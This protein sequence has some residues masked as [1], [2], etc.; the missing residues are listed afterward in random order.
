[1]NLII[2]LF[3]SY[4]IAICSDL[5]VTFA[6]LE[7]F[8]NSLKEKHKTQVQ[9]ALNSYEDWLNMFYDR[10]A[11]KFQNQDI[12]GY[13]WIGE[14]IA[15]AKEVIDILREEINGSGFPDLAY[16][17]YVN[18]NPA[19]GF[20]IIFDTKSRLEEVQKA[21]KL[22]S[23]GKILDY[24]RSSK[25]YNKNIC[26][27]FTPRKFNNDNEAG[28]C[29]IYTVDDTLNIQDLEIKKKYNPEIDFTKVVKGQKI[30]SSIG[31]Y[32]NDDCFI[33]KQLKLKYGYIR[34]DKTDNNKNNALAALKQ[35]LH[36]ATTI[37][38][39]ESFMY[40]NNG[41]IG[42][43]WIGSS[44][45]NVKFSN[46][47]NLFITEVTTY[48]IPVSGFLEY[49][50]GNPHET[51]GIVIYTDK[52]RIND[53][54]RAGKLWSMG[55]PF[56]K[57]DSNKYYDNQNLC[58]LNKMKTIRNDEGNMDN[59]FNV[60][61][62]NDNLGF[63]TKLDIDSLRGYNP[64]TDFNNLYSGQVICESIG[65]LNSNKKEKSQ[66]IFYGWVDG[67]KIDENKHNAI[68]LLNA[69][70]S[71]II[72]SLEEGFLYKDDNIVGY[73]WIGSSVDII[74]FK[75]II[76]MYINEVNTYSI[77]KSSYLEF[78]NDN[79]KESFG[80]VINTDPSAITDVQQAGKSWSM[81][82]SFN[83]K[84]GSKMFNNVKIIYNN[85]RKMINDKTVGN[86]I[87]FK[88]ENND[89]I[90]DVIK[91]Y[92]DNIDSSSSLIGQ[93][94]CKSI[95][96]KNT[97]ISDDSDINCEK[98]IVVNDGETCENLSNTNGLTVD[99]LIKLNLDNE[100]FYG[101]DFLWSGDKICV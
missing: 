33:E 27:L 99:Q 39:R 62:Y 19:D 100:D 81:G 71:Y 98:Y 42:L 34:G 75:S 23:E 3:V 90:N 63:Y 1:M 2:I 52:N 88:V 91:A 35:F 65:K 92:N 36:Q 66:N 87:T 79:P 93:T 45:S 49:T 24:N 44:I 38:D 37:P 89:Q 5:K 83:L 54:R 84:T 59:C 4:V 68:K 56:D 96:T 7:G 32:N 13:M 16:L 82:K 67:T 95:G 53:V 78:V 30:C 25:I 22:W 58:W 43:M 73:M 72:N 101:C 47:I 60:T 61:V 55:K 46:I 48:G 9:N 21:V 76:D 6:W 12:V 70:G 20:G 28:S 11:F 86:C 57:Q 51:I 64:N 29:N 77:P 17:E 15:N 97:V 26:Y 41:I 18:G 94:L 14:N 10:Q 8:D 31:V 74:Q 40:N 80:I 69:F 50:N 85:E